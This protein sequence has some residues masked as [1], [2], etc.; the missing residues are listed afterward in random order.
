MKLFTWIAAQIDWIKSFLQEADGKG[1]T[2]RLVMLLIAVTFLISY[3]K[4]SVIN[5]EIAD[6]PI[7]W[8]LLLASIIGLN[9]FANYL[10]RKDP[11]L[12]GESLKEKLTKL[13][14]SEEKK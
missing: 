11:N 13:M 8:A 6:V 12:P 9:I 3:N 7:N 2:K 14:S 1:S 4:I 5:E 10:E